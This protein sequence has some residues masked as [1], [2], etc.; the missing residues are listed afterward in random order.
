MWTTLN[1]YLALKGMPTVEAGYILNLP[2]VRQCAD[3]ISDMQREKS[4]NSMEDLQAHI[5]TGIKHAQMDRA[6]RML[7]NLQ[8]PNSSG[9]GLTT[10]LLQH[11]TLVELRQTYTTQQ[12]FN[13]LE[14]EMFAHNFTRF[15][16]DI[17]PR[18]QTILCQVSDGGKTNK[19]NNLHYTGILPHRNPLWCAVFARGAL[20]LHRFIKEELPNWKEVETMFHRPTLRGTGAVDKS[21]PAR[22][23]RECVNRLYDAIGIH[24]PKVT[25]MG[26]RQGQQELA[27]AGILIDDIKRWCKYIYDEQALSYFLHVAAGPMLQR[28]GYDPKAPRAMQAPHLSVD[29]SS[30]VQLICPEL[31]RLEDEVSVAFAACKSFKDAKAQCLYMADGL[32]RALR[33][34]FET[35]I[36]CSAARPRHHTTGS[37]LMNERPLFAQFQEHNSLFHHKIFATAEFKKVLHA[38]GAAETAEMSQSH[39]TRNPSLNTPQA[40]Q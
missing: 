6:C 28:C 4:M 17:G 10:A 23:M 14:R 5:D 12:R 34:E 20:H 11:N 15:R 29:V 35:F 33:F 31:I 27:D 9:N 30:L 18:G 22:S 32:Y 21:M 26:R 36:Q 7:W 24:A 25:H 1:K 19:N 38:I 37:V 8:L 13:D 3:S 40:I 39:I 16:E 2:G